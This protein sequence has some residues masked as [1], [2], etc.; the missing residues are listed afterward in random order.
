MTYEEAYEKL[1]NAKI[2]ALVNSDNIKV[3]RRELN[4]ALEALWIVMEN[5]ETTI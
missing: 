4:K 5:K 2:E 1:R 3:G